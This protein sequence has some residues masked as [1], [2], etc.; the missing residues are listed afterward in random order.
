[1]LARDC[2]CER[3]ARGP[4]CP[5]GV[6]RSS[7]GLMDRDPESSVELRCALENLSSIG[8]P[9]WVP[10]PRNVAEN[11]GVSVPTAYR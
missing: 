4:W 9:V 11:L 7:A 3:R 1:M 8:A 10:S 2:C 5:S 6:P